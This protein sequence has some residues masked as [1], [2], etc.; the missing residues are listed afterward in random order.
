MQMNHH[1]RVVEIR[2]IEPK[3]KKNYLENLLDRELFQF[4]LAFEFE[5]EF[6]FGFGLTF[7]LELSFIRYPLL[8]NCHLCTRFQ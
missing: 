3:K 1:D 6:G 7:I 8:A 4:E 2:M 5:F